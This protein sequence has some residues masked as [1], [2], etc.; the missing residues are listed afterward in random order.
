[1]AE[2]SGRAQYRTIPERL[3]RWLC[4]LG[5]VAALLVLTPPAVAQVAP[6]PA[7]AAADP[8]SVLVEE[9]VVTA[10]DGGPAFWRVR[11]GTSVVH[12]LGVP[13]LA[14]KRMQWDRT[15]FMRRLQ[16]ANQVILPTKA[17]RVRLASSPLAAINYL[18]L[19]S[20]TPFEETLPSEVKERFVAA[21]TSL[22]Q[23]ARRY[24]TRNALAA[25]L[26]LNTDYRERWQLTDTDP[27]KL[28]RLLAKEAKVPVTEKTYDLAPLL[29]KLVSTPPAA[30]RV[31]L[32]AV[33]RLVDEGP[34]ATLAA[35]RAWAVGDVRGALGQERT[36]ERCMNE[37][38]GAAALDARSKADDAAQIAR[39]LKTPGHSI[40]VVQLRPLLAQGGV[41]DR[42]RAQGFT[43][44]TPGEDEE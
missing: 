21:R 30:G 35:T 15:G 41:L 9:L 13:S 31:C 6:T 29:G 37:A 32:E 10:R 14:P 43:V 42:L 34:E 19:K 16:G 8:D 44:Q 39:A 3:M 1:M 18:R 40:A 11:N 24:G 4:G 20:G 5:V 7:P 27:I 28:I 38:P 17:M 25:A 33:L 26:L 2:L 23:P 12:V 22:G 36:Y